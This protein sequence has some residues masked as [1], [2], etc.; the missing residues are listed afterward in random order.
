MGHIDQLSEWILGL[1]STLH[2]PIVFS[3]SYWGTTCL[4]LALIGLSLFILARGTQERAMLE[5]DPR[6]LE[7]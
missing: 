4:A 1:M 7:D 5:I 6:D 3:Q 2:D